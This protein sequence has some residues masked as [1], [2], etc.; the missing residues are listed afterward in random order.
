MVATKDRQVIRSL[1]SKWMELAHQPVMAQRKRLWKAVHDLKMIR[2]VI[3]VET[4]MMIDEFVPPAELQCEDPFLRNVERTM[5]IETRHAE[6]IGDDIVLEPCFRLPWEVSV[7][8]YGVSW[9]EFHCTDAAGRNTAYSF[10]FPIRAPEDFSKLR[11][12][13]K[14][15]DRKKTLALKAVLEDVMGDILPVRVG[16]NDQF[17]PDSGYRPWCGMEFIGLTMDLFKLCGNERLLYWVYDEPDMIHR[18]MAFLRD[19]RLAYFR[20]LEQEGLLD[21]NTDN[22]MAGPCMYGYVSDLPETANPPAEPVRL[23]QLWGW[24]E[25]QETTSVSPSMFA[26]FFLP[27][28]AQVAEVFGLTYWG[29]CERI[30]DRFEPIRKAIPTLRSVSV[31]G[32]NDFD[33]AAELLGRDF[34]YSRKPVPA[35]LSGDYPDWDMARQDLAKTHQA[36]TRNGCNT[37]IL[38][39]DVYTISFDRPRLRRWVDMCKSVFQM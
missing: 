5:R 25:S 37:E 35:H 3:L 39:R 8:N 31:S 4:C 24:A 14:S 17:V 34:V 28:I 23:N 21:L 10:S 12:R 18:M 15:V 33:K 13:S 9:D 30:D 6:E 7:S 29:C 36:V 38:F 19:D 32:W 16:N 11:I 1:A 22:Q 27:Y 26:E 2:P 20:W